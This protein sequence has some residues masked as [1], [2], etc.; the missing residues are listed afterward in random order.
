MYVVVDVYYFQAT[1]APGEALLC[2]QQYTEAGA[3]DVFEFIEIERAGPF[4]AV[5]ETFRRLALR[6]VQPP[7]ADDL[8]ATSIFDLKHLKFLSPW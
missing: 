5:H 8:A 6:G 3:R 7:A 1:A 2:L 4:E